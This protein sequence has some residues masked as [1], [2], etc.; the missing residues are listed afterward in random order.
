MSEYAYDKPMEYPAGTHWYYSSGTANIVSFLIR[1]QFENDSSY[2]AFAE[3]QLFDKLGMPDA[4]FE[5]DPSGTFVGSSYIY[6][7][8]RDYA[9]FGL[10][11]LNDGIF[12]GE[13]ILPEGWVKYT[14]TPASDSKGEYGAFFW[15]NKCKKMPSV[16]EDIF[17]C[18]GHDGQAIYIIPDEEMVVV[19]LGYSP[20]SDQIDF[21][22]LLKDI[23]GTLS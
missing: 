12:N 17:Y 14:K 6:A 11:Y 13:R 22:R 4:E 18:Q 9:R 8:A 19:I 16:S 5:V 20:R 15:L 21:N 23:I 10:L 2:Y 1:E 7:T 3:T